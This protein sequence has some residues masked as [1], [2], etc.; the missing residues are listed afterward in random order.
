MGK[1]YKDQRTRDYYA[2]ARDVCAE[3]KARREEGLEPDFSEDGH[4][5]NGADSYNIGT[6]HGNHRHMWAKL[7]VTMRR[8]MKKKGREAA[9]RD[10]ED[11][12]ADQD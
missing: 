2:R 5:L 10:I 7:K 8:I 3:Q 9:R 4:W 1:T 11:Q 12:L 6:R